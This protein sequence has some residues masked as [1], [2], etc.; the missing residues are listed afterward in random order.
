MDKKIIFSDS[1]FISEINDDKLENKILHILNKNINENNGSTNSNVGGFQTKDIND[2]YLF[3]IFTEKTKTILI[4]NFKIK[5]KFQL[6]MGNM[7]I[8][9]NKKGDFNLPHIHP[10]SNFS[11]VFYLSSSVIGGELVFNRND[12]SAGFTDNSMYFD[13]CDFFDNYAIKPKKNAF[14]LFSSHLEH[15]VVPHFDNEDRIS[16]SFNFNIR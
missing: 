7:W 6:N 1:V 3:K 2:E 5:K 9:C 13:G 15:M 4:D 16:V 12:K 8:N 14:I 11:G 10:K